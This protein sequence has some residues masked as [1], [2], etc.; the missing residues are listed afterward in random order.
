[1]LRTSAHF[2]LVSASA[3][4]PFVPLTGPQ[5][6]DI[7]DD[8]ALGVATVMNPRFSTNTQVSTVSSILPYAPSQPIQFTYTVSSLKQVA[9]N[10][11]EITFLVSYNIPMQTA[12][13]YVLDKPYTVNV[14]LLSVTHPAYGLPTDETWVPAS[15]CMAT[16]LF[17]DAPSCSFD[18]AP[19][20]G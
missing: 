3:Q 6:A 2:A 9:D 20:V 15:G 10:T 18:L 11:L 13:W 7:M 4:V 16:A 14:S 5:L 19:P 12:Q 17:S 1:M 8:G